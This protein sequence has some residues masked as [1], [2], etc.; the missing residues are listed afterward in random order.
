MHSL[1]TMNVQYSSLEAN[2]QIQLEVQKETRMKLE[3]CNSYI[4]KLQNE[5][6]AMHLEKDAVTQTARKAE[7]HKEQVQDLLEENRLLEDNLSK[8]CELPF[9]QNEPIVSTDPLLEEQISELEVKNAEYREQILKV[10]KEK[11][12]YEEIIALTRDETD[13]WKAQYEELQYEHDGLRFNSKYLKDKDTQTMISPIQCYQ[14]IDP[15]MDDKYTQTKELEPE[16][17]DKSIQLFNEDLIDED[18]RNNIVFSEPNVIQS[19][20]SCEINEQKSGS[21]SRDITFSK[22]QAFSNNLTKEIRSNFDLEPNTLEIFITDVEL[23]QEFVSI[24]D[25]TMVVFDFLDF[26]TKASCQCNGRQPKYDFFVKY[27]LSMLDNEDIRMEVETAQVFIELYRIRSSQ[28]FEVIGFSSLRLN[29]VKELIQMQCK[30]EIVSCCL[31]FLSKDSDSIVGSLDVFVHFSNIPIQ[32]KHNGG[33]DN[34]MQTGTSA[35]EDGEGKEGKEEKNSASIFND[36]SSEEKES[37]VEKHPTCTHN[38]GKRRD[39]TISNVLQYFERGGNINY[40]DFLRFV[41]PPHP[42]LNQIDHIKDIISPHQMEHTLN[43][44]RSSSTA[45][46]NERDALNVLV[47][48]EEFVQTVA[49]LGTNS[50]ISSSNGD[51]QL[52]EIN[53]LYRHIDTNGDKKVTLKRILHFLYSP[54]IGDVRTMFLKYRKSSINPW[55]PFKVADHDRTGFVPKG[56]FNECLRSIGIEGFAIH[57]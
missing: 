42:I 41:D 56:T 19:Q 9:V 47:S 36:D 13:R 5:L 27:N 11:K 17:E 20:L 29:E 15:Q 26:D 8:L 28:D 18:V 39:K 54:D 34:I 24:H 55:S 48:E 3:Q 21:L 2:A 23:N 49:M 33:D 6:H 57:W 32:K 10:T 38:K 52:D 25:T 22:N 40:I 51:L 31:E 37:C 14:S 44:N 46:M 4:L 35:Q 7:E 12:E 16:K 45:K 43:Y 1:K 53:E 30:P 50:S